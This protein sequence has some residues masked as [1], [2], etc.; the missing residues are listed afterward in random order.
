MHNFHRVFGKH[1]QLVLGESYGFLLK[2]SFKL[3]P[4]THTAASPANKQ[5]SYHQ[6]GKSQWSSRFQFLWELNRTFCGQFTGGKKKQD[7]ANYLVRLRRPRSLQISSWNRLRDC[8][9]DLNVFIRTLVPGSNS[10]LF[11]SESRS[12]VT[13]QSLHNVCWKAEAE[14]HSKFWG[15]GV[16]NNVC[17]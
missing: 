4:G 17:A 10:G 9:P 3:N 5:Q 12:G 8:P 1:Q 14:L 6:F 13:S 2:A 16:L 11:D 15:F 7:S